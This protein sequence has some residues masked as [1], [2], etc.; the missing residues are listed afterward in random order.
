M[1]EQD[2][3][4]RY[5]VSWFDEFACLCGDCP[6]SC[7]RGWVIPLS[8][9][10]FERFREEKGVLG[11]ALFF[12]TGGGLREKFNP[13]SRSC[14]FWRRDGLC[15]LQKKRGHDFIPWTCQSYPRFYRNFGDFEECC[16]DLSCIAATR[17]F[18]KHGG[19]T[20]TVMSE[21]E[22]VTRPCTTNDDKEYLDFLLAQRKDMMQAIRDRFSG[23]LCDALYEYSNFL[24]DEIVARSNTD[25]AAL[26][27]ER[28]LEDFFAGQDAGGVA[29]SRSRMFPMSPRTLSGFLATS[30]WHKKLRRV[31]P[32]LYKM[33]ARA[34]K[35]LCRYEKYTAAWQADVSA[36]LEEN[37]FITAVL[38]QYL[39]YYMFQYFLRTFETY[40]F[41]K[42]ITLGLC[43]LNMIL[44][45][46]VTSQ[47]GKDH[48]LCEDD[49]A[50][51]ISVYNRRA[52]FNDSI[53]D[54]MYSLIS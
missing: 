47:T 52:Y 13:S 42:Q 41:R 40:S 48:P 12:A 53:T 46:A 32:K 33:L 28:F 6:E 7:C 49:L 26:S 31:S 30:L 16:L 17:L 38:G 34:K 23:A 44:L 4:K 22:P 25:Y 11:Y 10:D 39:A 15:T 45:L 43:H 8:D 9:R 20:D 51:M 19:T 29:K 37:P 54:E 1:S 24:Q 35:A 18:L 21:C 3:I 5:S 14:P 36:L 2:K 50:M 27:F